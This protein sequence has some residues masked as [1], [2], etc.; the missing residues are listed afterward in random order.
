[1]IA[2]HYTDTLFVIISFVFKYKWSDWYQG[3]YIFLFVKLRT[4]SLGLTQ[5]LIHCASGSLPWAQSSHDLNLTTCLHPTQNSEWA[6]LY[7]STPHM[8]SWFARLQ[9]NSVI[10]G[11]GWSQNLVNILNTMVVP[12]VIVDVLAYCQTVFEDQYNDNWSPE[13]RSRANFWAIMWIKY[14]SENG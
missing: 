3:Q 2:C 9:L 8:P 11:N 6:E 1:M 13:G 5:H 12:L 7:I 10:N 14:V 4:S